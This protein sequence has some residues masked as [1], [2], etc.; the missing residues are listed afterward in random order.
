MYNIYHLKHIP[1]NLLF[2]EDY[3]ITAFK[4]ILEKHKRLTGDDLEKW[5]KTYTHKDLKKF[6]QFEHVIDFINQKAIMHFSIEEKK[7]ISNSNPEEFIKKLCTLPIKPPKEY[8]ERNSKTL[9]N[10]NYNTGNSQGSMN[11]IV[12][13][14]RKTNMSKSLLGSISIRDENV[15]MKNMD[16]EEEIIYIT[17]DEEEQK[18]HK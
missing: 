7:F 10:S 1:Q 3:I 12:S 18:S 14:S 8:F 2:K 11:E 15:N 9:N 4:T 6:Y 16:N 17:D 5:F 13:E